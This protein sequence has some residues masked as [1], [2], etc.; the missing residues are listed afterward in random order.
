MYNKFAFNNISKGDSMTLELDLYQTV[1]VAVLVFALGAYLRKKINWLEKYC[2]PAP[3]IGGILFALMT[4]FLNVTDTMS[5]KT[6]DTMKNVFMMLFFTT[7]GYTASLKLL[8]K[9]GL[10]VFIFVGVATLL[11]LL[12]NGIGVMVAKIFNLDPLIGLSVG[13]IPMIGGHGT[14]GSFGPLLEKIGVEGAT[15]ISVSSATFGLIVGGLIGGPVAKR[16]IAKHNLTSEDTKNYDSFTEEQ[17]N[18]KATTE[19]FLKAFSMLFIAAGIGSVISGLIQKTGFTFPSYIGAMLAAAMLRNISDITHRFSVLENII[20]ILG[21]V[22]LALFLSMALMSLR[23]WELATL[24][25]PMG[26]ALL[27]QTIVVALFAYFVVFKIMG[28]DYEAAVMSSATCGFGMGATPNAIA[29]MQAITSIYGP[30]HKA[31]FIVPLVGS[32]FIDFINGTILTIF[33]NVLG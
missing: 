15:T 26:V 22:S 12:E 5:I 8:K 16:L 31:F 9:G 32:L 1:A 17:T 14:A 3:V 11:V 2:I 27:A 6:D 19:E 18:K 28:K 24:A 30:A 29:N 10:Q 13:S 20:E 21:N 23:L 4:L 33:I 25:I 7:V